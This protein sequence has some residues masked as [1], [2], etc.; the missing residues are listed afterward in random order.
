MGYWERTVVLSVEMSRGI[1]VSAF[2]GL[3]THHTGE[4]E[5]KE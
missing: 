1:C 5:G 2:K 3:H 4:L